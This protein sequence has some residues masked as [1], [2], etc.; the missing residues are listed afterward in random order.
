MGSRN[1]SDS[2]DA[3]TEAW[4]G[5]GHTPMKQVAAVRA[6]FSG[7]ADDLLTAKDGDRS[8]SDR[9]AEKDGL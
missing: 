7:S 8:K 5:N 9:D 6:V 1:E 3:S 2:P 4:P